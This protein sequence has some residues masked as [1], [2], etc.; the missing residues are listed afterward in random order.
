MGGAPPPSSSSPSSSTPSSSS[1]Q[2]PKTKRKELVFDAAR[3]LRKVLTPR[4]IEVFERHVI[5]HGMTTLIAD[6]E[7]AG[8]SPS[9][10]QGVVY[11]LESR[12]SMVGLIVE[13]HITEAER[14]RFEAVVSSQG[15]SSL[16]SDLAA[17]RIPP[18]VIAAIMVDIEETKFRF[19]VRR[20]LETSLGSADYAV[21]QTHV[22]TKGKTD[23]VSD[24]RS[25]G[26]V[27]PD[28]DCPRLSP[29]LTAVRN[30]RADADAAVADVLARVRA[31][32]ADAPDPIA[33]PL[34]ECSLTSLEDVLDAHL[35]HATKAAFVDHH[36]H[37]DN[38]TSNNSAPP[39]TLMGDLRAA[40]A[41]EPV[42]A[43]VLHTSSV[44]PSLDAIL[45]HHLSVA[46]L[47]AFH[48]HIDAHGKSALVNDL[49]FVGVSQ[50][51]IDQIVAAA[52]QAN[53]NHSRKL[54]RQHPHL[55]QQQ[56]HSHSSH[57][58]HSRHPHHPHQSRR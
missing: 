55:H 41:D 44:P 33:R 14:M 35:D 20:L 18:H 56:P 37:R 49:A 58:H 1:P 48:A 13:S 22:F 31:T 3:V 40:G 30:A 23:L 32:S 47:K 5:T 17:A 19:R 57:S 54:R 51:V 52:L 53:L 21:F 39:A 9:S 46:H 24:L 11:E 50:Q 28:R 34:P 8:I 10:V 43:A 45:A 4:E 38:S 2:K 7:A 42:I 12:P 6:L 29:I 26:L 16:V 15:K 36:A 25:A 27:G